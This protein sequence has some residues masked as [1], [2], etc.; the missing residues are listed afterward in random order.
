MTRLSCPSCGKALKLRKESPGGQVECPRCG[1]LIAVPAA[2]PAPPA[3]AEEE[4]GAFSRL[5]QR[6]VA[7]V[8]SLGALGL[9]GLVLAVWRPDLP[10]DLGPLPATW[11]LVL[12]VC[13][14]SLCAAVV[15]GQATRCP[16]C[17]KWWSRSRVGAE[18]VDKEV[19]ERED[20]THARSLFRATYVCAACHHRWSVIEAE[21]SRAPT[22]WEAHRSERG[23]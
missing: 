16:S 15:W 9:L 12:A 5:S 2:K 11:G 17:E 14:F 21:E 19:Y 10:G 13:S 4:P 1:E 23:A 20:G 18:F 8:A 22:R 6:G 7:A 3:G